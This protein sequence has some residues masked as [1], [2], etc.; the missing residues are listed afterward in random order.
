MTSPLSRRAWLRTTSVGVGGALLV[1]S[2]L[3]ALGR[4]AVSA[5]PN[6]LHAYAQQ[7]AAER[8]AAGAVRLQ[9]NENPY[10]MSPRA[11]QAMMDAWDEHNKY[12]SPA[13]ALLKE[14]YAKHV[15]VPTE[16][17]MVTQGSNEVICTAAL[18]FG[19]DGKELVAADP[20]FETLASYG[21]HMGR[22]VHKVPLNPAHGHDLNAMD[23]RIT[24]KTG[25]VFV[26]NPNN[27]TGALMP[28]APLREFVRSAAKR[29]T[30]LVDEA[31]HEYVTDTSYRSMIDLVMQG[32][33]V[34]VL[35]TASKIHGLAGCRIGFAVAQPDVIARLEGFRTGAPN[36]LSARAAIAA[37][38]DEE[39][40][41]YCVQQNT[42]ARE[43]LRSA[44]ASTGRT[45]TPSQTNFI[46]FDAQQP[47]NSVRAAFEARG[48]LVGRAF[49]PYN[50]WVRV[51]VGTPDEM[52][53]FAKVLPEVLRA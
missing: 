27:P 29:T 39:W 18:A 48:F 25:L 24:S 14:T 16:Y 21:T 34:I 42:E 30:V 13:I 43:I 35:R 20:T 51:S 44:I 46:F 37:I 26:C 50:T 53:A 31:Y 9:S 19:M 52:R 41:R 33:N 17:V 49:P 28:N 47:T 36:A 45:Q 22:T 23:T 8:A 7:V 2:A 32:D 15:G 4:S 10:G 12:G 38:N 40:P 6:D 3:Q 1:P 5:A 11:K